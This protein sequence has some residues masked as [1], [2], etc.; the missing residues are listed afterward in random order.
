MT[1]R[2][3][4]PL[5]PDLHCHSDRSDGALAPAEVVRRAHANGVDMLALT[6]HDELGGIA[7]AAAEAQRL[8]IRLVPGVEISV[9]WGGETIHV[10]GLDIDPGC[11]PLVEGLRRIRGGR[12]GRAREMAEGL[13][14][15]G[16][17]DAY[18]GALRHAGDPKGVS[19]THF[20]RYI[21]EQGLCADIGQAFSRYLTAGRPGF[22]EHR[23]ARLEEAMDWIRAAGGT[24][25]IAHPGRYRLGRTALLALFDEFRGFGG[26]A[27]EV[28]CGSHAPH[29]YEVFARHALD[30]GL[31]ASRGSDFHAPGEGRVELGGLPPLPPRLVP[32][33]RDWH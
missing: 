9:T 4:Q 30:L 26:Q 20:A 3:A 32:V 22:V 19:R 12:E 16:I 8:G 13:A 33:W 11:V 7:E 14:R 21:V 24:A 29:Q 5:N 1:R 23:W 10:L 28:V 2:R 25:V 18:E 27:I 15:A 17:P 6:D 31:K